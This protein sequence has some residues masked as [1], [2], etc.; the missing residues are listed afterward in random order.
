MEILEFAVES[1]RYGVPIANVI[2]I[3]HAV[4]IAPL[5][6]APMIVEGIIDVRGRIVPVLNLRA[7]F[8]HPPR[9]LHP[10]EHFILV[11][12]GIR[13]VAFRVDEALHISSVP[14]GDIQPLES[15]LA[16]VPLVAG[17]ARTPAGMVLIHDPSSFLAEG[18]SE[19][20]DRALDNAHAEA[21]G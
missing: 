15:A 3:L 12:A 14:D 17:V 20:L 19:A 18:E 10:S 8:R 16:R 21:H 13:E 2:E 11:Q 7:R 4:A 5:P 6:A 1:Q 9:T